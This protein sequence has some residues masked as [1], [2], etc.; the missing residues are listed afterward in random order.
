MRATLSRCGDSPLVHVLAFATFPV[1]FLWAQNPSDQITLATAARPLAV[2]WASALVL[3][4]FLRAVL[5]DR[6]RAGFVTSLL[7]VVFFSF[8]HVRNI[9][10]PSGTGWKDPHLLILTGSLLLIGGFILA[11]R[12]GRHATRATRSL[13]VVAGVLLALNVVSIV[14]GSERQLTPRETYALPGVN[15]DQAR[16]SRD[17]YYLVFDRYANVQTLREL[18]G[19]DNEPFQEFLRSEGFFVADDSLANYQKTPHS[20]ASSLNMNYLDEMAQSQGADSSDWTPVLASLNGSNVA[21]AFQELG[22]RY[23]HVGS[24]WDPTRRDVTADRFHDPGGVSEFSGVLL[25]TTMWPTLS[26]L[27]GIDA[28]FEQR[29]YQRALFQFR[30]IERIARDPAPTFTFVHFLLPHPPYV[31]DDDGRFLSPSDAEEMGDDRAYLGQ[32]EYTNRR[33]RELVL[34]LLSGSDESDP[35]IVIQSDE[36]PNPV[37]VDEDETHYDWTRASNRDLGLKLR[38][39][40][41]YYLPGPGELP[42]PT[43]SPVNSFRL[44]FSRYFGADL[45]LLDDRTFVYKDAN[46]PYLFTDVTDR[47]RE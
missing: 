29:Q 39:L 15:E 14:A 23:E 41:A 40:N 18:Y 42:Y 13:N 34:D 21:A 28:T 46:H 33:I 47:L 45:P 4:T 16:P 36:G 24:W 10:D 2:I 12:A 44:V 38:I 9:V 1:V 6:W 43:I 22:Y 7:V 19:F 3:F 17:V 31:F 11:M 35:I 37:A 26:P 25:Q 32:L 5:R 8:G 27:L 30:T 20:L